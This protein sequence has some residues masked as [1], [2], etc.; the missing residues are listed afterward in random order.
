MA[1][2]VPNTFGVVRAW[3]ECRRGHLRHRV[4]KCPWHYHSLWHHIS[5]L[6]DGRGSLPPRGW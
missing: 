5:S 2:S 4:P 3:A 1:F 6:G